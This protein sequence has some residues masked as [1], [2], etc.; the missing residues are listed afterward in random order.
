MKLIISLILGVY[1]VGLAQTQQEF[2][3]NNNGWALQ[4]GNYFAGTID[5]THTFLDSSYQSFMSFG[6]PENFSPYPN[7]FQVVWLKDFQ[8]SPL[9]DFISGEFKLDNSKNL[10]SLE[11]FI[12]LEAPNGNWGEPGQKLVL[13]PKD[14]GWKKISWNLDVITAIPTFN[15]VRLSCQFRV[16]NLLETG[17]IFQMK[18]LLKISGTD[19]VAIDSSLITAIKEEKIQT[20]LGF[21]LSQNYP[22]PFNPTTKIQFSVPKQEQVKLVVFNS[23]GQEVATLVNEEKNTGSYSVT[24][25]G[26]NLPSGVYFYRL[27]VGSLVEIK[28]MLLLK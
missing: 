14:S 24:F 17:G 18:N 20:P 10:D 8:D 21:E 3:N 5:S 15:E 16:G 4:P 7:V 13:T 28:K 9:P 11:I 22:N 2:G 1:F 6:I 25:D 12:R 26:S 27:Q 23:L 19:T